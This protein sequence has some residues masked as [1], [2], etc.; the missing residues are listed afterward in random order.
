MYKS[1]K[2]SASECNKLTAKSPKE[3]VTLVEL[4][5]ASINRPKDIKKYLEKQLSNYESDKDCLDAESIWNSWFPSI[6]ADVFIS[7][8]SQ[9]ATAAKKLSKYLKNNLGLNSFID[10]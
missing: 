9:D 4:L 2:I 3:S 1:F 10:S 7:H 8:S 5:T 6:S